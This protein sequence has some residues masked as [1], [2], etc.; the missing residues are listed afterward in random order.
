MLGL[1]QIEKTL[2]FVDEIGQDSGKGVVAY[3]S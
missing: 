2:R 3:A 1:N